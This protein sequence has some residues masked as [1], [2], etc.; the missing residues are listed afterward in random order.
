MN[1]NRKQL[2]DFRIMT[3][4]PDGRLVTRHDHYINDPRTKHVQPHQPKKY[5][6]KP[7]KRKVG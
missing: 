6:T 1:A 2:I 5:A 3:G 4:T 7:R